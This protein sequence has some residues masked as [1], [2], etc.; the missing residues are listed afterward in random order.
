MLMTIDSLD[1][2]WDTNMYWEFVADDEPGVFY[3]I[4]RD[5]VFYNP[6][7]GA[8]S[9][10]WINYYRDYGETLVTTYF[11]HFTAMPDWFDHHTPV[12]DCEVTGCNQNSIALRWNE[13]E[14]K[15]DEVLVGYKVYKG[16][17]LISDLITETEYTDL[18][19]GNGRLEYHV[20]AVYSD[21][22][23]SKSYNIVYCEQSDGVDEK[24]GGTVVAVYPNPANGVVRI[25]G[26]V[27]DE[28]Q[29]YNALGQLVKTIQG[30]NE[31]PVA[32]LPQGVYLL[33]IVDDEGKV[34]TN[35]I[36]IQ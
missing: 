6:A 15:P 18:Y 3:S 2:G 14:L 7:T 33:R 31:I 30:S 10:I 12:M 23:T 17:D 9:K 24:G 29:V 8:D 34:Y 11:H 4:I 1:D 28:V 27:A 19:S 20:L 36:M 32:D 25:E 16:D 5:A 26:V 21:G 22:E 35:K 13:P